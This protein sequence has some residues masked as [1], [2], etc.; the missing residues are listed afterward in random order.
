MMEQ[1]SGTI[2]EP[3]HRRCPNNYIQARGVYSST[4]YMNIIYFK[5]QEP[6]YKRGQ[7]V[8]TILFRTPDVFNIM[9]FR[10]FH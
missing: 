3:F 1:N 7:L 10:M 5:Q 2:A 9:F 6:L 4:V 8:K